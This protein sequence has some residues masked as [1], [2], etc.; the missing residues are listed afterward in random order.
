MHRAI[1]GMGTA[2]FSPQGFPNGQIV[3]NLTT[4][5]DRD[6]EYLEPFEP[7]RRTFLVR[8][9]AHLPPV[10]VFTY[11]IIGHSYCRLYGE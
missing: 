8:Q 3:Y 7:H 11:V 10:N 6:H 2:M 1:F 9:L 5:H 4:T